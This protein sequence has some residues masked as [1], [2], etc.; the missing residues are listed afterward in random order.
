MWW[1]NRVK[2]VYM[3]VASMLIPYVWGED[4]ADNSARFDRKSLECL[5]N[6]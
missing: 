5:L 3:V 6:L 4:N 2:T 1:K